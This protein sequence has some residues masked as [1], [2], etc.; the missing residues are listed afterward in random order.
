MLIARARMAVLK[1]KDS[2][3]CSRTRRRMGRLVMTTSAVCA[4]TAIV[5]EKY[6]KSA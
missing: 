6:R 5:N 3:A 2:R 1:P 4:A